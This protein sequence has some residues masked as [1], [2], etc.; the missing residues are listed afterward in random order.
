M[1]I[2]LQA[3]PNLVKIADAFGD[4]GLL[5]GPAERGQ[6]QRGKNGDDGDDHEKFDECKSPSAR[7]PLIEKPRFHNERLN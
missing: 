5:F 6:Q 2:H 3:E 7:H 4:L 1:Q